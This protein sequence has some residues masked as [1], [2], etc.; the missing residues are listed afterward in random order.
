MI[1]AAIWPIGVMLHDPCDA[2]RIAAWLPLAD[3]QFAG[4]LA[5]ARFR[6]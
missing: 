2:K 4:G 5:A 1:K 6:P 3:D